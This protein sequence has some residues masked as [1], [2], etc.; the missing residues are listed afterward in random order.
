MTVR[1]S[2]VSSHA[3]LGGAERYLELLM[4][5]LGPDWT[6]GAVSLQDGPFV[7]RL[8]SVT[9]RLAVIPAPAGARALLTAFRLRAELGR[10]RPDVVHANGLK[11]ALVAGLATLGSGVPVVWVKHDTGGDGALAGAVGH[12]SA[13]IVGVSAAVVA[14]LPARLGPKVRVVPNGI[15]ELHADARAGRRALDAAMGGEGPVVMLAGRLHPWKGQ[16]ELVEAAPRIL[17]AVSDARVALV[18]GADEGTPRYEETLRGR[19][20]ELG[21][22]DRVRPAGAP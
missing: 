15:A 2:F 18:G 22:G 12:L 13:A 17:A 14:R 7:A 21:L 3:Q 6:A 8:R 5:Q 4:G 11:A 10:Q 16:L 1:V 20:A 19:I 9:T